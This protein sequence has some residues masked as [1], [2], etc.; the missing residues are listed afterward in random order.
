M[1]PLFIALGNRMVTDV[2]AAK[3]FPAVLGFGVGLAVLQGV[4]HAAGGNLSGFGMDPQVDDF[5]RKQA[6]KALRRRPV[7]E[8]LEQLGER[9]SMPFSVF[10]Y[11]RN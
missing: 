11:S 6:L 1:N 7:Q 5:D 10:P 2:S 9:S 3:T 4:F 8:T